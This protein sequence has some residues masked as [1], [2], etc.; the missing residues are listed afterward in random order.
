MRSLAFAALLLLAACNPLEPWTDPVAYRQH[1]HEFFGSD[2]GRAAA[3]PT[4]FML[5][6]IDN[7]TI[8]HDTVHTPDGT[9]DVSGVCVR[10]NC[11]GTIRKR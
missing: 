3:V 9:F 4:G 8:Y 6:A 10:S 5:Q 1:V 7:S 11:D 2:V